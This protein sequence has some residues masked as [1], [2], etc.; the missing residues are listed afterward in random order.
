LLREAISV[1]ARRARGETVAV[2]HHY[3]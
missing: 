3:A 2:S 1:A